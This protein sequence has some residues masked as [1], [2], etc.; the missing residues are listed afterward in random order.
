LLSN[1][2]TILRKVL[3]AIL[4]ELT[5]DFCWMDMPFQREVGV[6]R[7]QTSLKKC[8]HFLPSVSASQVR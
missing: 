6:F 2:F 3:F 7:F 5:V 1:L 8:L 4:V